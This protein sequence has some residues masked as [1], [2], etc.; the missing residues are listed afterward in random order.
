MYYCHDCMLGWNS[1]YE[2]LGALDRVS[3]DS[4]RQMGDAGES[5]DTH[6]VRSASPS[7]GPQKTKMSDYQGLL[8]IRE[9][10]LSSP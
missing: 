7:Q 6:F 9:S 2:Y 1:Q 10:S 4:A 5:A 8:S 3:Y